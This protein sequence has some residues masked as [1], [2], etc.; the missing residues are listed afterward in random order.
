MSQYLMKVRDSLKQLNEWAIKK[1]PRAD[2]IQADALVGIVASLPIR[3]AILLSIHVQTT[4]FIA[5]S[6]V[7]S[8][9]KKNQEWTSVIK[10]YL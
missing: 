7:C 2:N 9:I 6:T 5:E 1:I 10:K 4:P 8:A 3:K